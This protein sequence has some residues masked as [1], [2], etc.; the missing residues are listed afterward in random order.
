MDF[1]LHTSATPPP[2]PSP[3]RGVAQP[4]ASLVWEPDV[5]GED[6]FAAELALPDDDEGTC[7]ATLVRY[8]PRRW[9]FLERK[10]AVLYVHGWN[11]Y[12]FQTELAEFWHAQGAA[13]YALDLRKYGRSLREHQTPGFITDLAGYDAEIELALAAIRD[14]HGASVRIVGMGHSTGGLILSLWTAR[15]PKEFSALVLNS[16]WLEL[17]G[18]AFLRMLASPMVSQFARLNP[19]AEMPN[20]DPGFSART[21]RTEF[22]GEWD[23]D[24]KWRPTPMFPVRVGWLKAIMNGHAAVADGLDID[25][26]ILT[27]ASAKSHIRPRWSEEMRSADI[28]LDVDLITHRALKLGSRVT[29]IRVAGG[30]HDLVMSRPEVRAWVYREIARWARAYV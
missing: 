1:V 22:G 2:P 14:R 17:Q 30:L 9:R 20:I 15:H 29:V 19:K 10:T 24:Q 3:Q 28:V 11:D 26:P 4:L 8:R 18:S 6:F 7:C 25:I 16:P 13:F 27:M 12:Y 5:L 23:Y 21:M